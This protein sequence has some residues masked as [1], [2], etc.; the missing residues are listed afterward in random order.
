MILPEDL[1]RMARLDLVACVQ[2]IHIIDDMSMIEMAIGSRARWCYQFRDMLDAGIPLIFSSDCPVAD[3]NPLWGIHAAVTRQRRDGT[4]PEGWYSSQRL[5]V[6]EAVWGY[7]MAPAIA[8]DREKVLG[9]ITPGRYADIVIL[10]R[11]IFAIDPMEIADAKVD[12]TIF[13]GRVVF[14]RQSLSV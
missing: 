5:T 11:N 8:S 13:N 12:F 1:T 14:Q 3:P 7:T 6:Q 9:S 4:T 2:P 10:D